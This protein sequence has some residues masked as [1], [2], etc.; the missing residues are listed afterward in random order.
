MGCTPFRKL[1]ENKEISV[2]KNTDN[3]LIEKEDT[4]ALKKTSSENIKIARGAFVQGF[5]GN[6]Y[7]K[8]DIMGHLGEGTYGRVLKVQERDSKIFRAM[9]II[10]KRPYISGPEEEMR[11]KKEIQ[12]LKEL[13]H[14]NI[15]KVFEF[16]NN[17]SEFYIISELCEGGELFDKIIKL[18]KFTEK[19]A[20]NVMKQ[21]LSAMQFC[22][23]NQ[24]LHRDLKPE[25]I[26]I[27]S[28]ENSETDDELPFIKVIDFGTAE[29][30]KKD[31]LLSKQIG[32]PYYIA[33]E[34][35]NNLYNEK[36][37]LWSCGIIMYILLS[38]CPPF[39]GRNDKE[40]YTSIRSGKFSFRQKVWESVS[41]EAKNLITKLLDLDFDKRPTAEEAI[42]DPWFLLHE[43]YDASC[44]IQITNTTDNNNVLGD[45]N[46]VNS[47]YNQKNNNIDYSFINLNDK[48]NNYNNC[49]GQDYKNFKHYKTMKNFYSNIIL[50]Q[51]TSNIKHHNNSNLNEMNKNELNYEIHEISEQDLNNKQNRNNNKSNHNNKNNKINSTKNLQKN[52]SLYLNNNHNNNKN[53]ILKS[54]QN[55]NT[56]NKNNIVVNSEKKSKTSLIAEVGGLREAL[57]NLKNF[58]AERKLQLATLYFMV[59]TLIAK[60][61]LKFIRDLFY[62]FDKDKDGRLTKE[63]IEKG[64]RSAKYSN[65]SGKDM[66]NLMNIV[67]MDCNGFI[68]YQ[69]FIAATYD[70][71]KILTEFNLRKAFDMFDK[72]KSGKISSDELKNVLGRGNEENEL[73][74]E[75]IISEVDSDRDGE[76]SYEEFK[77]MMY[78][79]ISSV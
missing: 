77:T 12:I 4:D 54:F 28:S 43:D 71:K 36:C 7:K 55:K 48:N 2:I 53:N 13:D 40:I 70:K 72:D 51:N 31:S 22:H 60:Q 6:P 20:A 1:N 52:N 14:P 65:F 62:N 21:I 24:I 42:K 32:T 9:K 5:L 34:V 78:N 61:D 47:H 29:I 57:N 45:N 15:I 26:I 66:E 39:Y 49:Y 59:H 16:Y 73:V 30:F 79:L 35:L 74:W 33:P 3:K 58:K 67:D 68:E 41:Q 37:D 38:G 10:K 27:D 8:Y 46:D 50:N 25:N 18:K 64:F 75:R 56:N 23:K 63:E 11:I 69:E 17:K 76:I 44:F 19:L